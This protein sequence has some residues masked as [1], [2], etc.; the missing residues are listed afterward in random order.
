MRNTKW[1]LA[2]CVVIICL[3]VWVLY[4]AKE[5]D[6]SKFTPEPVKITR[7][8]EGTE[9]I[10][11]Q[12]LYVGHPNS[13]REKDFVQFLAEHFT[14]VKTGDLNEFKEDQANGFDV[15]ILDYDGEGLKAPRP[16]L[17]SEYTRPTVTV[18]VAGARICSGMSLK[19]GYL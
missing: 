18:G 3:V 13:S 5:P 9:K 17:S 16:K 7:W 11:L 4:N 19:T 6:T 10:D 14:Q 2:A 12:I 1:V 8:T 15:I